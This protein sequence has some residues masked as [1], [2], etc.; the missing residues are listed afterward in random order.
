MWNHESAQD[1]EDAAY[2]YTTIYMLL[3]YY[4]GKDHVQILLHF[5]IAQVKIVMKR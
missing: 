3:K 1:A 5:S 4:G 2:Y